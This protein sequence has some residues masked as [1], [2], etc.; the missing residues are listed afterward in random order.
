MK[1]R[2]RR[3]I[4][5]VWVIVT[6]FALIGF[7]GLAADTGYVY[8]TAHHL[9]NAADAAALAGAYRVRASVTLAQQTAIST[10]AANKA[11]GAKVQLAANPG[12]AAGGDVVVGIYD[13]P[14]ATFTPGT[15]GPNAVQVLARRTSGSPGGPLSL[16]F[17]PLF[18]VQTTDVYRSAIAMT[19]GTFGAGV[20]LLDPHASPALKM[21]GTGSIDKVI[22]NGGGIQINSD[23]ATAVQWTGNPGIV[24]DSGVDVVGNDTAFA[25]SGVY[26]GPIDVG[27]P[28][29]PDPLAGLAPP[30]KPAAAPAPVKN[31]KT[32]NLQPGYYNKNFPTG[33]LVLASG[34]YYIDGGISLGGNDSLDGTAGVMIFLN[35]GGISMGG[36]SG[37]TVTPL[38]SGTYAGVSFYQARGNASPD[39]LQG[40]SGITN[41][42]TLYFPSAAVSLAGTPNAYGSQLIAGTLLVQ[43]NAQTI[44]NYDGRNPL[45][46]NQVFLVK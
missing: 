1:L 28:V 34:I 22:V 42:G 3:G 7:T 2:N 11:A 6:A 32:T 17:G 29:A 8:L 18:G 4:A 5:T 46:G 12:N 15:S 38:S 33:K 20:I 26:S 19:G 25:G 35:T 41:S 37:Y 10:A 36:T 9:Q 31:G 16:L 23:S 39:T 13:R 30:A 44:I 40:T 21:T 45:P 43:G 24:A 27:A 14:S